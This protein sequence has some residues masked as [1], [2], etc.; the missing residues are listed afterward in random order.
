MI[1]SISRFLSL[2]VI[3]ARS[4]SLMRR[5]ELCESISFFNA[6]ISVWCC[7]CFSECSFSMFSAILMR[8][9]ATTGKEKAREMKSGSEGFYRKTGSR[10]A[11]RI[12]WHAARRSPLTAT[13]LQR[14][15]HLR[16][17]S[18]FRHFEP[19]LNLPFSSRYIAASFASFTW[20][21]LLSL[22]M[23]SRSARDLSIPRS[24]CSA[25]SLASKSWPIVN[26]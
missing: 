6:L 20:S 16:H 21:F 26:S 17:T 1:T 9:S 13:H 3:F 11:I 10:P 5:R 18:T 12:S 24:S 22:L 23:A 8:S 25:T 7:R 4:A 14:S 15:L 19:A 2:S